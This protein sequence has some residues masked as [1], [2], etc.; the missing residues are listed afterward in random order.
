MSSALLA[1]ANIVAGP[2]HDPHLPLADGT[3]QALSFFRDFPSSLRILDVGCGNG[4]HLREL[5]RIGCR[6]VGIE[7]DVQSVAA[8][9]GSRPSYP[10]N[11][12][13]TSGRKPMPTRW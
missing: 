10:G 8:L 4:Q 2:A 7:P 13:G 1:T 12:I 11:P 9:R 5:A 6:A 3:R